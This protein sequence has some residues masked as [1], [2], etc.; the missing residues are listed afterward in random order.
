GDLPDATGKDEFVVGW[1]HP[2]EVDQKSAYEKL[3]MAFTFVLTTSGAPTIYYGDEIGMTGA[4]DPDNRRMFPD[5]AKLTPPQKSV[6]EHVAK[7]N[8]LRAKHPAIRY[9]SRRAIKA[10]RDQYAVVRT[11]L[12]DRILI[13][14]N[15]SAKPAKM[16]LDIGPEFS[17]GQIQDQLGVLEDVTVKNGFVTVTMPGLSSAY[18]IP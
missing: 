7:L 4:Q 16:E 12:Q 10:E 9:G 13:L 17:D 2:P 8:A 11:Y 18:L 14:Y 5:P 1:H 3:K 6:R 15:R